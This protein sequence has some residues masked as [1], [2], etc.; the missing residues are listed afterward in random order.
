MVSFTAASTLC[1]QLC[2]TDPEECDTVPGYL[3]RLAIA[4]QKP[5]LEV[6]LPVSRKWRNWEKLITIPQVA[7]LIEEHNRTPEEIIK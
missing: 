7:T 1:C 2:F 5:V 4:S 3:E 6:S